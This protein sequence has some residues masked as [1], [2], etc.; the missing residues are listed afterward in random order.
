MGGLPFP[1]SLLQENEVTN[2][3]INMKRFESMPC[4]FGMSGKNVAV[5]HKRYFNV[6]VIMISNLDSEPNLD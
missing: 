5:N 2:R 1:D 4:K 6:P 3:K